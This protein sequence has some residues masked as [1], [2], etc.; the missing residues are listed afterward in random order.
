MSNSCFFVICEICFGDLTGFSFL[1]FFKIFYKLQP[2]VAFFH[3]FHELQPIYEITFNSCNLCQLIYGCVAIH[4]F[5]V[6][7][8]LKKPCVRARTCHLFFSTAGKRKCRG[9]VCG[10]WRGEVCQDEGVRGVRG[11]GVCE[12]KEMK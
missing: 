8:C 3:I 1:V 11:A 12:A 4:H 5:F 2:L 6:Y 9:N 7:M 10:D